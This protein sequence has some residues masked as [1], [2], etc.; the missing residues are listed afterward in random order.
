VDEAGWPNSDSAGGIL[1][2]KMADR[3]GPPVSAY[4]NPK[5]HGAIWG[6]RFKR[7]GRLRFIF[8]THLHAREG[9]TLT[10]TGSALMDRVAGELTEA[11]RRSTVRRRRGR[12]GSGQ[13]RAASPEQ[14]RRLQRAGRAPPPTAVLPG[15]VQWRRLRRCLRREKDRGC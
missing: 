5:G 3:R 15:S 14:G 9:E 8:L 6:V 11:R 2:K 7:I 1:K 12:R 4:P 13:P 10:G